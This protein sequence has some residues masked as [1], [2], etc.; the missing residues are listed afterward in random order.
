M[1]RKLTVAAVAVLLTTGALHA[2]N[3]AYKT[4]TGEQ[5]QLNVDKMMSKINWSK[6]FNEL[7]KKAQAERKMIFWVDIV[8]DI[9]GGL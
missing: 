7:K 2:Q 1:L 5:V 9:N 3:V 8:G 4:V 6:D